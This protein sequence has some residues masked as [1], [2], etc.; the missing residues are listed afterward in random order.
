MPRQI[1]RIETWVTCQVDEL[2]E[3]VLV[4]SGFTGDGYVTLTLFTFTI[5]KFVQM[6]YLVIVELTNQSL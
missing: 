6:V 2:N 4:D 1:K 3:M 5:C